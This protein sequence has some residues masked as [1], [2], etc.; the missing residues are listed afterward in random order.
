MNN[1][2][3]QYYFVRCSDNDCL[4]ELT[5]DVN[6]EDRK[7]SYERQPI[8]SSPLMFFNGAKEYQRKKR[9]PSLKKLPDILFSGADLV[10]TSRLREALLE[11]DIPNLYMHP[12]VYVHDDGKWH[13]DYWYLTFTQDFD[14]WDRENSTYS[15]KNIEMGGMILHNVYSYS[16]D[17][18]LLEK[19]P[20]E[21]RLLFKMGG[22]LTGYV[23]CHESINQLFSSAEESGA[24]LTRVSDY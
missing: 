10:V 22:T 4:P 12:T 18:K 19:T 23:V 20:I 16:L 15:A 6:T 13:E 8:G 24:K 3:Q 5:P 21:R 1:F 11:F 9:I 14:C 2:D 17:Q 7:F